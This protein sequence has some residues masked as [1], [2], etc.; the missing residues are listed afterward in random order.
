MQFQQKKCVYNFFL[1]PAT[2]RCGIDETTR[3]EDRAI[4]TA[5]EDGTETERAPSGR[6]EGTC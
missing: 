4:Q 6:H 3:A 1:Q 5:E 2:G